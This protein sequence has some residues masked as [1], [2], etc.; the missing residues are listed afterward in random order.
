MGLSV[1]KSRRR[2]P[3]AVDYDTWVVADAA[4]GVQLTTVKGVGE[5]ERWLDAQVGTP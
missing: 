5:L 1:T 3:V 4:T 2:L